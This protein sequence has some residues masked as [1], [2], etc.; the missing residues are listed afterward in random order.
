M[1]VIIVKDK[2]VGGKKAYDVFV[3]TLKKGSRTFGLATGG[4]P[5]TTYK[6]LV[7][8]DLD[9]T[10]CTSVN[11]DEYVGLTPDNPQSYNYYMHKHLFDSKP[12]KNSYLPDGSAKDENEE[13]KRYNNILKDNPIDLQLLGIG[14]N[15]HIGFNEPGSPI[16]AKTRKV[17]LT[18]STIAANARYFKNK[19]EVPQYA[20]SMGIGSIMQAKEILVEAFGAEKAEAVANMIEGK[21][22]PDVPAS[23][24]Q[25]HANVTVIVDEQAAKLLKKDYK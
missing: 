22:S 2:E 15:G 24:L 25:R 14:K 3:E 16:D 13:I 8:S 17:H 6:Q 20:Y 1:K 7:N 23:I 4:T 12:F 5:E 18:E 21:V 19:D 11:L 9:F 10:D